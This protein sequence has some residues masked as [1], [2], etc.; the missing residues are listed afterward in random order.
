MFCADLTRSDGIVTEP[1]L[2][3]EIQAGMNALLV[4]LHALKTESRFFS[5]FRSVGEIFSID[6]GRPY[7][8]YAFIII[9]HFLISQQYL[10]LIRFHLQDLNFHN[11][12]LGE[13]L[14]LH[15]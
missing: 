10:L 9:G 6:R 3:I 11:L 15:K 12:K 8:G 1:T 4:R 2:A 5:P 13:F 14:A 7:R